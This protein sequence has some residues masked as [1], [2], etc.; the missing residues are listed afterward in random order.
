MAK[1]FT[2]SDKWKKRWFRQLPN[3][4]KVFWMYLLDQCDHA[5]IWEVD[6]DL[7]SYFCG[8]IDEKKIRRTFKKQFVEFDNGKRWFIKDFIQFQYNE[9]NPNANAHKSVIT[10]LNKFN[11][12]KNEVSLND[13]INNPYLRVKDKDK[14]K[15]KDKEKENK[16]KQIKKI[17]SE[18][19]VLKS[20]FPQIDVENEFMKWQD[21]MLSKG[22]TYKNYRA[23][24]RNWLRSDFVKQKDRI[25]EKTPSGLFKAYCVK[26][27]MKV[28]PNDYQLKKGSECC[29]VDFSPVPVNGTH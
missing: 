24:F 21:W 14:D 16:E 27:G 12:L 10:R 23:A 3:D 28:N 4:E 6:F 9:L 2:D 5:G 26:C 7:A 18:L 20:E 1:R 11:L 13:G 19:D 17:E 8:E 22:K 25:F 29:G 15:V